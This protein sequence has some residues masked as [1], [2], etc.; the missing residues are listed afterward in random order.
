MS[1]VLSAVRVLYKIV[2]TQFV[3]VLYCNPNLSYDLRHDLKHDLRY[4]LRY[5]LKRTESIQL[6]ECTIQAR[7]PSIE[8]PSSTDIRIFTIILILRQKGVRTRSTN[9]SHMFRRV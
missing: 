7:E 3:L 1:E 8:T 2:C 6:P 9:N 5:D 4:D